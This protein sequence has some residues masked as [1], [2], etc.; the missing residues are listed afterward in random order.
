M[1]SDFSWVFSFVGANKWK[2]DMPLEK[3]YG[4]DRELLL[5]VV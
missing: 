5:S 1:N 3:K 2:N 4:F